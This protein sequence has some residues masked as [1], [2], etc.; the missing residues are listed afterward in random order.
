MDS[1]I[2]HNNTQ[3]SAQNNKREVEKLL[4]PARVDGGEHT[5]VSMIS[6]TGKY[7]FFRKT[8]EHFWKTYQNLVSDN[9][10]IIGLAEK[11]QQY[12][13]VLVDADI[14]VLNKDNI[15]VYDNGH[16]YSKND[17]LQTIQTYQSILNTVVDTRGEPLDTTCVVL[18]KPIYIQET[19]SSS[20]VKNG[21]HLHFPSVFVNKFDMKMQIN[22]RAKQRLEELKVFHNI[23]VPDRSTIIDDAACSVPWLLLNSRKSS[24]AQ[25]YRVTNV[26]DSDCNEISV[27]DAFKNYK[28][29][30]MDNQLIPIA[31]SVELNMP[32]ILSIIPTGRKVFDAK[33]ELISPLRNQIRQNHTKPTN[34]FL[35]ENIDDTIQEAKT[36]VEM[37]NPGRADEYE[38]WLKIGFALYNISDGH[39]D[40]LDIWNEFS[41]KSEKYNEAYNLCQW[42]RMTKR[43]LSMGT[44]MYYAKL[45]NP[46]ALAAYKKT[47]ESENIDNALDGSHYNA[48]LA[49][50]KMHGELFKCSNIQNN[51][52][53][54]FN[55][56]I[57]E[58]IDSAWVLSKIISEELMNRFA[59]KIGEIGHKIADTTDEPMKAVLSAQVKQAQ[60]AMM[61]CKSTPWK[62]CVLKECRN[63]FYDPH[64]RKKLD[65]DKMKF[66]FKNGVYDLATHTLRAGRPDDYI[67][68]HAPIDYK[69]YSYADDK[70]LECEELLCKTFPDDSIRTYF[71]S[72]SADKF[73]GG[74]THKTFDVWTGAGDNGK[75]IIQILFEK[76]LGPMAV[77][78]NT[79][80]FTGKKPASGC[81]NPELIRARP[82][83][84]HVTM[85]E[86]DGDEQL[87][88]G[89]LKKLTGQDS[90]LARDLFQ[91]GADM[92]E[93]VP[94]F[95]LTLIC[96]KLPAIKHADEATFRRI[97]VIP[98]ESQFV[99]AAD[100]PDKFEDQVAARRF[101]KDKEFGSKLETLA[102]PMAWYLL[103]YR[104][105]HGSTIVIPD[106]VMEATNGYRQQNDI[107]RQF[108]IEHIR[109]DDRKKITVSDLYSAFKEWY[110]DGFPNRQVPV[111]TD[112]KSYF[113]K[114]WG[115]PR[116]TTWK[117]YYF[118]EPDEWTDDNDD[119]DDNN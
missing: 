83:V 40:A 114:E 21:F 45:D 111:Q 68:V 63:V 65:L 31:G 62:S 32:R 55:G 78:F 19:G 43:N 70:I 66:A 95:Q 53:Y 4:E 49:L 75:S 98:F 54:F 37:I 13:A 18:E 5:H 8:I 38:T 64:F 105:I 6:P 28:L 2:N 79:Q 29:Y 34:R 1:S 36:I 69:Q 108:G 50:H 106:K 117:G 52:W 88:I 15:K 20:Y 89:E 90:F 51:E 47:Q 61:N 96:N 80:Y 109:K 77:K 102:E 10:T 48:A 35:S 60:K 115:K 104:E 14:R 94:M 72:I 85:E 100:C 26:Y 99:D 97:R 56:H 87:N 24:D 30:D 82:P 41:S 92:I 113:T 16:L 71:T 33:R 118:F 58:K 46:T 110:R 17:L 107:Y 76:I 11:P 3:P 112:L 101:P 44:L 116:G 119:N 23:N 81:A 73:V 9:S 12:T 22:P 86:P 74:N 42:D 27:E 39:C 59:T 57:W 25:P 7:G 103:K 93:V 84:R 91:K 67:S